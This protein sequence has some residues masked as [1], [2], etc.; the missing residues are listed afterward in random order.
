[1]FSLDILLHILQCGKLRAGNRRAAG[2]RLGK[3]DVGQL[4]GRTFQREEHPGSQAV[5]SPSSQTQ[6]HTLL[7]ALQ[8]LRS[9]R[10]PALFPDPPLLST[11]EAT[12]RRGRCPV[13]DSPFQAPLLPPGGQGSPLHGASFRRGYWLL[14]YPRGFFF[15][16]LGTH[17]AYF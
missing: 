4:P 5:C 7:T 11:L 12:A 9:H 3:R 2:S 15:F 10:A 17:G 16:N 13:T 1:M 8:S 14:R 6:N